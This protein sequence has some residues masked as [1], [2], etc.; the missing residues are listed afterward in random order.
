MI[1]REK[2]IKGLECCADRDCKGQECPYHHNFPEDW[3]RFDCSTELARDVLELLKPKLMT[4]LDL[5]A[6]TLISWQAKHGSMWLETRFGC[7]AP[8]LS[9]LEHKGE[10]RVF[11]LFLHPADGGNITWWDSSFYNK[12]WR[13]WDKRPSLEQ[14]EAEKWDDYD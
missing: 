6:A 2:V 13:C 7:M 8:C 1:D 14:R 3:N 10:F 11:S 9:D 5:K 12:T 4:I